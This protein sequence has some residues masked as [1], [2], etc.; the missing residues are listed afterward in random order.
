MHGPSAKTAAQHLTY[1]Y[2]CVLYFSHFSNLIVIYNDDYKF[3]PGTDMVTRWCQEQSLSGASSTSI[4]AKGG[5]TV[6]GNTRRVSVSGGG[7]DSDD[8]GN[9]YVHH[10]SYQVLHRYCGF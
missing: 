2:H 7:S 1:A 8:I 4:H 5:K 3:Q 10:I 9:V 6:Q